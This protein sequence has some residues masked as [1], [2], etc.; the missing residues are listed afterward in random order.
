M[1]G[2]GSYRMK[3]SK[4]QLLDLPEADLRDILVVRVKKGKAKLQFIS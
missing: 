2:G 3:I 4:F 1:K